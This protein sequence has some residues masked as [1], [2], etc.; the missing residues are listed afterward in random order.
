MNPPSSQGTQPNGQAEP[1]RPGTV[2][3]GCTIEQVLHWGARGGLYRVSD[4]T[5]QH[6]LKEILYPPETTPAQRLER[7]QWLRKAVAGWQSLKHPLAISVER[8]S[9]QEERCYLL[10]PELKGSRLSVQVQLRSK[11][12]EAYQA[13][14]WADQ[15]AALVQALQAQNNPLAFELLHQDRI[16]ADQDGKLVVFNPGWTELLWQDPSEF[17]QRPIHEGLKRYGELMVTITTGYLKHPPSPLDLPQGL[18]WPISRCLGTIKGSIYEDFSEVRQALRNLVVQGDEARNLRPLGS[19]PP[20]LDYILPRLAPLRRNPRKTLIGASGLLLLVGLVWIWLSWLNPRPPLR[21]ALLLAIDRSLYLW[22]ENAGLHRQW[23][24][25]KKVQ[26]LASKPDG[27]R[28]YLALQSDPRMWILNPD[29]SGEP[30][31]YACPEVVETL[32]CSADSNELLVLLVSGRLLRLDARPELPKIIKAI[33]LPTGTQTALPLP[34]QGSILAVNPNTGLSLHN[35]RSGTTT[36]AW[37]ESGAFG[38]ILL[39]DGRILCATP[40]QTLHTLKSNLVETG[41]QTMP[42]GAGPVRL[43]ASP[44]GGTFWSLLTPYR[45]QPR[46]AFWPRG[47]VG[48]AQQ[49]DLPSAPTQATVDPQGR[50]WV[51]TQAGQLCLVERAPLR[52][53]TVC[54]SLPGAVGALTYLS[55]QNDPGGLDRMLNP[56]PPSPGTVP[57]WLK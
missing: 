18:I 38:A 6:L 56:P 39:R 15:L 23:R 35:F 17:I 29:D 26:C 16:L 34:G 28:L 57:S 33:R 32:Q 4:S 20:L 50:L 7:G 24:F 9:L 2:V 41:F 52:V 10:L 12:P 51:T 30:T 1:S 5:G 46:V 14:L 48:P 49:I 45:G 22:S 11:P 3:D 31:A 19:M 47:P 13:T 27:T 55:P 42:G 40:D 21:P 25:P 54:E 53:T 36:Q 37:R 8:L 44:D 43:L